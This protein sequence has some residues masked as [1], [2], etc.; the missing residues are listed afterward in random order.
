MPSPV[1]DFGAFSDVELAAM[2]A[3]AKAEYLVRMTEGRVRQGG[4]AAQ[5]YGMD[6]MTVAELTALIN[7][8][9]AALG[10][11]NVETRVSPNF[12]TRGACVNGRNF[13]Y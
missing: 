9:T 5:Q 8:L 13:G 10:L 3:A 7:G 6:L 1:L 11:S 4:S 12:N 2:L